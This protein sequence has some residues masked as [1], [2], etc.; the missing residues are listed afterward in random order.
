MRGLVWDYEKA[1]DMCS[2]GGGLIPQSGTNSKD[3][4]DCQ[5]SQGT[6]QLQCNTENKLMYSAK[7]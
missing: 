1:G 5:S 2:L 4:L 7:V 3:K 6:V